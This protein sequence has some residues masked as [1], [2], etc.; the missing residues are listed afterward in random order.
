MGILLALSSASKLLWVSLWTGTEKRTF[1][2]SIAICNLPGEMLV[3]S[4]KDTTSGTADT[5]RVTS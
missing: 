3:F 5:I 2:Q 1:A 4:N